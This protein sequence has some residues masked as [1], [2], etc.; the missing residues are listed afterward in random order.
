MNKNKKEKYEKYFEIMNEAKMFAEKNNLIKLNDNVYFLDSILSNYFGFGYKNKSIIKMEVVKIIDAKKG[1]VSLKNDDF[2]IAVDFVNGVDE[3]LFKNYKDAQKMYDKI[4]LSVKY[5]LKNKET[6][7]IC[8]FLKDDSYKKDGFGFD[9]ELR[10]RIVDDLFQ[11]ERLN[12]IDKL[13]KDLLK[14][15]KDISTVHVRGNYDAENKIIDSFASKINYNN[16]MN[17]WLA[18]HPN[19]KADDFDNWFN[20]LIMQEFIS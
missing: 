10:R 7:E 5:L 3:Y 15:S 16:Y 8:K 13:T 2:E 19:K 18:L 9:V 6:D 11:N 20:E 4:I 1:I 12:Y 14:V 17:D